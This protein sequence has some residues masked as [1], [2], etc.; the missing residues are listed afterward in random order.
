MSRASRVPLDSNLSPELRKFHDDIERRS[1]YIDRNGNADFTTLKKGAKDAL[2]VAADQTIEAG[3]D[4]LPYSIGTISSGTVTIDP[5]NGQHQTLTSNGA[6]ILSP[7][8]GTNHSTVV[9]HVTNG[10]SAGSVTFAGWTKKYPSETMTTTNGDKF[11]I[12]MYFYGS[13]GAD[14]A[15]FKRQ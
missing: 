6:F 2:T 5:T 7:A 9:L 4:N 13:L 12:I 1:S 3:F 15:V 10:A 14:Y 8:S 11:A